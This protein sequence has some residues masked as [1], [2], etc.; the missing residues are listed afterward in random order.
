MSKWKYEFGHVWSD[1]Y[2]TAIAVIQAPTDK[3]DEIGRL[4]GA[5]PDLLEACEAA[6]NFSILGSSNEEINETFEKIKN[7]IAKAKGE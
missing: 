2:N 1:K 7:A 4:M 3:Q 6:G 5:A